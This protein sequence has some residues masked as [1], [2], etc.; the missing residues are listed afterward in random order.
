MLL[1]LAW[2]FGFISTRDYEARRRKEKYG[3]AAV[4]AT[5]SAFARLE[6]SLAEDRLAIVL[7]LAGFIIIAYTVMNARWPA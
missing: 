3:P 2:I 1:R 6:R 5:E 4:A 7:F